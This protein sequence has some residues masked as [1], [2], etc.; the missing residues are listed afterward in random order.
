MLPDVTLGANLLVYV[1]LGLAVPLSFAAAYRV[2]DRLSLGNYVDQYQTVAPDANR[3]LEAPPNDATVDGEICPH[4]GERND[5]TF[6]FCRS[7]T[8]RVAV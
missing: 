1:A 4:C 6:E 5:P 8:A 2:V 7:C 3:A